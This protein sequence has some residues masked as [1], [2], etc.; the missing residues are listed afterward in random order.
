MVVLFEF[1]QVSNLGRCEGIFDVPD[2]NT[3]VLVLRLKDTVTKKEFHLT[4]TLRLYDVT[5]MIL[6]L[7]TTSEAIV[8]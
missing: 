6:F 7:K 5:T 4:R 8:S 1:L 3:T 2:S